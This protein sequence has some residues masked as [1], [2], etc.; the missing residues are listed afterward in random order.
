MISFIIIGRNEEKNLRRCFNSIYET[1][2]YNHIQDHEIIYID[3]NST[4]RSIEIAKEFK[5]I[6]I[7]CVTG[8]C[9][10]AI[11]RNIGAAESKGSLLF[12]IDGDMEIEKEFFLCVL[13]QKMDLK[14]D[15]V[16][17]QV[18]DIIDGFPDIDRYPSMNTLTNVFTRLIPGGIFIIKR[19]SWETVNGM[20]TK[21]NT[22][23]EPDLGYRLLKKGF[24]VVRINKIIAKHFTYSRHDLT[25][26]WKGILNKSTFH[27]KCVTYRDHMTNK[28]MYFGIWRLDKTFILLVT[29][30]VLMFFITPIIPFLIYFV[31]VVFRSIRQVRD[32]SGIKYIPY[33]LALDL[34]NLIFLFTY[35]PKNK[36]LEYIR[37]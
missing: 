32:L 7:Y 33:F 8:Y 17:G 3:S 6:K 30:I 22:G 23:E 13:D 18:L 9:N 24:N 5:N 1:I 19:S 20:R 35:F 10:A 28:Y 12:F 25:R 11:G 29:S 16:S 37:K 4:D 2:K 31:A 34:L 21:F 14:Y 27:S 36:K 26:K 15:L